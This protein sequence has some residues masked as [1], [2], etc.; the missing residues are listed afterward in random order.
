MK[1]GFIP[2]S[3]GHSCLLPWSALL[4]VWALSPVMGHGGVQSC[5]SPVVGS[6]GL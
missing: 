2:L 3:L 1:N 5:V 6:G 4:G